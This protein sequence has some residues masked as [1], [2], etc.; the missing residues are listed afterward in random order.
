MFFETS[1]YTINYSLNCNV[2]AQIYEHKF[3]F[4]SLD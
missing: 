2:Y 3:I 4:A 1:K